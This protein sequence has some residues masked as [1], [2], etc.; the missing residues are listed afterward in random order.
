MSTESRFF[1]AQWSNVQRRI[2]LNPNYKAD[3]IRQFALTDIDGSLTGGVTGGGCGAT[4]VG[5]APNMY[6]TACSFQS[7][8]LNHRVDLI[9]L[10]YYRVERL[11]VPSQ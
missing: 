9:E 6:S 7:G 2:L 1:K 11:P 5:T 4:I 10:C 3:G 8:M